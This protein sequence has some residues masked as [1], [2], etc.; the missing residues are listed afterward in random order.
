MTGHLD[1]YEDRT[2]TNCNATNQFL[3][4]VDASCPNCGFM[5]WGKARDK[6][7]ADG[8]EEFR[9]VPRYQNPIA[10]VEAQQ[11]EDAIKREFASGAKRDTNEGKVDFRAILSPAALQMFGDYMVR[12]NTMREGEKRSQDN[13]KKGMPLDSFIESFF[14][15]THE[16]H[17]AL[18]R[19]D[20]WEIEEAMCGCFFNLQGMM[21]IFY[22]GLVGRTDDPETS[23]FKQFERWRKRFLPEDKQ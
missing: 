5:I 9:Q 21:D 6:T 18:E 7:L 8:E 17:A 13:W 19:D 14:R 16:L 1:R 15:H 10:A 2:C 4:G 12:H 20:Q 22:N 23:W 3:Q 11:K